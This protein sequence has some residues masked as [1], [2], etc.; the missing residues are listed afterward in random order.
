MAAISI[1]EKLC[2]ITSSEAA[3]QALHY[4]YTMEFLCGRYFDSWRGC[5]CH[6][7]V[8]SKYST[9][10]PSTGK[11]LARILVHFLFYFRI[12]YYT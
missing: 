9:R 1:S 3:T 12:S 8:Y 7:A 10:N 2:V 11:Q 4:R 5:V 6:P